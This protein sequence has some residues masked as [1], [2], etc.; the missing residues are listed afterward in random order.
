[1]RKERCDLPAQHLV[2]LTARI[3]ESVALIN[4]TLKRL[5]VEPR[6]PLPSVVVHDVN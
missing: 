1:V 3:E 2:A 4:R 5:V 6:D